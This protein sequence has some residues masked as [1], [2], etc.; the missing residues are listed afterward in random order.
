MPNR[1]ALRAASTTHTAA[2]AGPMKSANRDASFVVVGLSGGVD[3]AVSALRLLRAGYRVAGLF[4]KNWE[5]DDTLFNC[6]AADDFAAAEEVAA[7]LGIPLYR[8]NFAAQYKAKVFQHALDELRR[9]RT[10]NPDILCNQHIKF[11]L[12]LNYA[13]TKLGANY[14]ATGHYARLRNR[15]DDQQVELLRGID[16]QKDQ[17]Y[18]LAAIDPLT[19]TRVLFPLGAST[20]GQVREEAREAGLPNAERADSTGIC[21]IGERDFST[22]LQSYIAPN[23]GP[24][25]TPDGEQIGEHQGL[26]FY[27]LGQRRGLGIGGHNN[28]TNEPWYIAAKDGTSNALIVVQ[29]HNHPLLLSRAVVSEP[30]CWLSSPPPPGSCLTAQ[31]RYRQQAQSGHIEYH[32]DGAVTF[33]FSTPQRAAT[34]GQYLVIY[35]AERCLGGGA[36]TKTL[37]WPQDAQA[38]R[39]HRTTEAV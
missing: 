2:N 24:I 28:H 30:I 37:P 3:S 21:F 11:H 23:P 16:A 9:G 5:D 17:S 32:P 4:M 22:F 13:L 31:I 18:F 39:P 27:T 34:P 20:K 7:H 1:A 35:A 10:P 36:I 12:F 38:A 33:H 8:V 25:F 6:S 14:I 26:A 15:A 29:G 19:L